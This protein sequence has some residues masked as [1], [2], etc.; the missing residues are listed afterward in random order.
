MKKKWSYIPNLT[1]SM[2]PVK[3]KIPWLKKTTKSRKIPKRADIPKGMKKTYNVLETP[4]FIEAFHPQF[5]GISKDAIQDIEDRND[6]VVIKS[7]P[8]RASIT[9][10][11]GKIPISHI[12]LKR[13]I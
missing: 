11:K 4:K 1:R 10:F 12:N 3:Y 8:V 2:K 13:V 5:I 6:V 9:F 7:K